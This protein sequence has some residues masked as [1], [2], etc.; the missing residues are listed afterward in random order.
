MICLEI[1]EREAKTTEH[2]ASSKKK[3]K[4]LDAGRNN[5]IFTALL[6]TTMIFGLVYFHKVRGIP[7]LFLGLILFQF[8]L[9]EIL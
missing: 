3:F 6:S 8:S 9:G 4:G 2:L 1:F 5:L 7:L